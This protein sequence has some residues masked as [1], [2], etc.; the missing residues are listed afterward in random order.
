MLT[1]HGLQDLDCATVMTRFPVRMLTTQ[2]LLT[3]RSALLR[4]FESNVN[5]SEP[6]GVFFQRTNS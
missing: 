4:T 1:L 6:R 2:S 3:L 5:L